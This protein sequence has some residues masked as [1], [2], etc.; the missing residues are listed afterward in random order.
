MDNNWSSEARLEVMLLPSEILVVPFVFF[1][2]T[3]LQVFFFSRLVL[4]LTVIFLDLGSVFT[5]KLKVEPD[6][7]LEVAL[8]SA[9]LVGAL[10]GII[11]FDINFRPVES[12]ITR[13]DSPWLAE[14]V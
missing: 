5:L 2:E 9:A 4:V 14:L 8:D 3:R 10:K 1:V 11:H 7:K 6:W 13:V 12:A